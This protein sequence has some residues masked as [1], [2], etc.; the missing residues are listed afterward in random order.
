MSAESKRISCSS[1]EGSLPELLQSPLSSPAYMHL[2][3]AAS[4][5]IVRTGTLH[6]HGKSSSTCCCKSSVM[7]EREIHHLDPLQV[8]SYSQDRRIVQGSK[9]PVGCSRDHQSVLRWS[10][11]SGLLMASM[12][13]FEERNEFLQ[14]TDDETSDS[15]REDSVHGWS[16]TSTR[17]WHML[18]A[19]VET[20]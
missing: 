7:V 17:S 9:R 16:G 1:N 6:D 19:A 4:A 3:Q 12:V 2:L 14:L 18:Q 20:S 13:P 10:F 8:V 11:L 15:E 5:S